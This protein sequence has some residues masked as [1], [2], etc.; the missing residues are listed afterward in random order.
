MSVNIKLIYYETLKY[1]N[2]KLYDCLIIFSS[3]GPSTF[4]EE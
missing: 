1:P 4:L 3:M 2:A